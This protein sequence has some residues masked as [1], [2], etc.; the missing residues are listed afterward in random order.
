MKVKVIKV[1]PR[2]E[3]LFSLNSE[4]ELTIKGGMDKDTIKSPVDN[5][6]YRATDLCSCFSNHCAYPDIFEKL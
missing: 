1:H 5:K 2:Y 6:D 3:E 4:T